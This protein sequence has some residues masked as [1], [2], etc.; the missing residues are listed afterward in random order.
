LIAGPLKEAP[1]TESISAEHGLLRWQAGFDVTEVVGEYNILRQCLQ[2]A[3]ERDGMTLKGKPLHIINQVFD[4]AIANA[5]K[6]FE[7]MMTIQLQHRHEEHIA[8]ILHDLRSPLEALSL[9][10][11]LLE[12]SLGSSARNHEI[13]SA[14]SVLRGNIN[15]M[16][17]RV[18]RILSAESGLGKSFHP[19]FTLLNLQEQVDKIVHDLE[20]LA[21][22]SQ[23]QVKNQIGAHLEVYSDEHL[24]SQILQNLISNA[25]K[26]TTQGIVEI[27]ARALGD[28]GDIECWV[29]DSGVGIP[30]EE[31][32][33]VFDRFETS[34]ESEK[35]GLG[36]GL[37][38]VKEIVE[39]HH[40]TI[41]VQS[42]VGKGSTFTFVLPQNQPS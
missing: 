41:T 17:E 26:F 6:A 25:L 27:G 36:L 24:L 31:L 32:G 11:T 23:T 5:I 35:T 4:Q 1:E 13:E 21:I 30:A 18:R 8:F 14:L 22:S 12:R 7:T 15:R 9:A 38:I 34:A 2:D 37:A 40:G 33:K 20:P 3:A 19:A 16:S 28:E 42:E 10:T 39:L 29:K